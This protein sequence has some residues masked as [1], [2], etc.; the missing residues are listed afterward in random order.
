MNPNHAQRPLWLVAGTCIV[1][2]AATA[3]LLTIMAG[4][5]PSAVIWVYAAIAVPVNLAMTVAIFRHIRGNEELDREGK[6]R[7]RMWMVMGWGQP[8]YV[9][10]YWRRWEGV[11][12][13]SPS[14]T[15]EP[16]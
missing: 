5:V 3:L 16:G 12:R 4:G 10:R 8:F 6:E 9:R 14:S 13:S 1:H 15:A 11:E 2:G 7:W